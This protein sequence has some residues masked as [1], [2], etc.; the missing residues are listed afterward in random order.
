LGDL[1][2]EIRTSET[3]SE[4]DDTLLPDN[5]VPSLADADEEAIARAVDGGLE[6]AV[7]E[8]SS[9]E[10]AAGDQSTTPAFGIISGSCGEL[11]THFAQ[12]APTLLV[13]T[14]EFDQF[15]S[16]DSSLL[17]AGA[18]KRYDQDN[19]G[20]SSLCSEVMSIQ[21]LDE[22][23]GATLFKMETEVDY[24]ALGS[25]ADYIANLNE[26]RV[27]VSVTRAYKGPMGDTYTSDDATTLLTKKLNGLHEASANVSSADAWDHSLLHVWTLRADW[28][29]ILTGAWDALPSEVKG[30]SIVMVTLEENSEWIVPE[31][32]KP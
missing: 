6:I 25:I 23:D 16:F 9:P 3:T 14:Y 11:A 5:A 21:L 13:N 19:Q 4:P 20:G 12:A 26:D 15:D 17:G 24:A 1:G 28:V 32:C 7:R 10:I 27:G 30:E 8:D 31:A 18:A 29:P 2:R 22:C